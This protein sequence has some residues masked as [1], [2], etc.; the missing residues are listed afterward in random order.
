[1][2]ALKIT[3]S[4]YLLRRLWL[5]ISYKKSEEDPYF[6]LMVD[7]STDIRCNVM[8][9]SKTRVA[10]RLKEINPF[11]SSVHY[12]AHQANLYV[13]DAYGDGECATQCMEIDKLV[14]K[15][16]TSAKA[17]KVAELFKRSSKLQLY[18]KLR[19][20]KNMYVLH[21]LADILQVISSLNQKFQEKLIDI[22][23]VGPLCQETIVKLNQYYIN[24][25]IDLNGNPM[26]SRSYIHASLIV[27]TTTAR[28]RDTLQDENNW[29]GI[30]EARELVKF[31]GRHLEVDG[32]FVKGIM[33]PLAF[34]EEYST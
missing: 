23:M 33:D 22:T 17:Q 31:Y 18:N 5:K 28:H 32:V 21:F 15:I 20:L 25:E 26:D 24:D 10:T 13:E 27:V 14:N 11:L 19:T 8:A 29:F 30:I 4:L 7:E 1:M 3:R 34:M 12:M 2:L 6:G 16:A 9:G